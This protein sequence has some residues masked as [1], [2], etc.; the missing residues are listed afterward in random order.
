MWMLLTNGLHG[1]PTC[2]RTII[3][4]PSSLVT[5]WGREIDKA[6]LQ[7]QEMECSLAAYLQVA[8]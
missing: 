5:N 1:L 7:A 3:L 4:T 8:F 2:A 6:G